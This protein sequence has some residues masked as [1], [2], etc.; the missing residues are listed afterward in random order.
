VSFPNVK[1]RPTPEEAAAIMAALKM[2][3]RGSGRP[4]ERAVVGRW[5]LAGRLGHAVPVGRSFEG[6]PWT[7][8]R[9]EVE[10]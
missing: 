3:D 9:L 7:L 1:P 8:S 10:A 4:E 5:E 2:L 6:S